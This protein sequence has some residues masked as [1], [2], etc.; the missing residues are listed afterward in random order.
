M[1]MS[2]CRP[3]RMIFADLEEVEEDFDIDEE[4]GF[5]P[6]DFRSTLNRFKNKL[7]TVE[8][9]CAGCCKKATGILRCISKDSVLLTRP[10]KKFVL[11]KLFCQGMKQPEI[12][13]AKQVVIL[14]EKLISVELVLSKDHKKCEED[15]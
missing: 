11:I 1:K 13:C 12:E 4:K 14:I 10:H 7:V 5:C 9:E 2:G 3:D 6:P 8:F 15:D